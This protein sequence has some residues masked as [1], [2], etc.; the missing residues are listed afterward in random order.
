MKTVIVFTVSR[1]N[2]EKSLEYLAC[3]KDKG[4]LRLEASPGDKIKEGLLV[5]REC[6]E[7]Y[8]INDGIP[9]FGIRNGYEW[10]TQ[11][12]QSEVIKSILDTI[13]DKETSWRKIL[14]LPNYF[15]SKGYSRKQAIDSLFEVTARSIVAGDLGV[16]DAAYLMQA[17]TE[18][19]YDIE[20][21][22][23]TFL[24]PSDI[25]GAIKRNYKGGPVIEGAC[26]TGESICSISD[27]LSSSFSIGLDIAGSLLREASARNR[28]ENGI[29][30]Q[31]DIC[32]LPLK[33]GS[34]ELAVLN[35]VFDR[36]TNPMMASE[37]IGRVVSRDAGL[38]ALSN[39]DP[40]QYG[41][42]SSSGPVLFVPKENQI[43]LEE[44][45][46]IA[47]FRQIA[48]YLSGKDDGWRISTIAYGEEV[49]PYKSLLGER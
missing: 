22:R 31:G 25:T 29:Y 39:C 44:G 12:T 48:S 45:L 43:S 41:Y 30:V 5:C 4:E 32:S 1:R 46:R 47:G 6:K 8:L 3:P 10:K 21:Y 27:E 38:F 9:Y 23:G 2:M 11:S 19:R 16:E 26:A 37:E 40:L 17:A 13:D 24:L 7:S 34:M 35:N 18:G 33:D 15:I 36:V 14:S 42:N 49:L 20:T 28:L